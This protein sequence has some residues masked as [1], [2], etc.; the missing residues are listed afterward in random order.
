VGDYTFKT[1]PLEGADAKSGFA[2]G[3]AP[4]DEYLARYAGQNQRAGVSRTWVLRRDLGATDVP[5]VLGY[6]TITLGSIARDDVP[7]EKI[8]KKLPGHPAPVVRIGRLASDTRTRGKGLRVG[9]RLLIDAHARALGVSTQAGCIGVVV[10]AK[11]AN[12]EHFYA[13]YGYVR[14]VPA[15]SGEK[16]PA[17]MYISM[18]TIRTAFG[19]DG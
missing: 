3:S 16:W 1:Q 7:A 10:D 6:Y 9:E 17:P 19:T 13:H 12:A 2:C 4:L 11:D 18:D 5:A 15:Q 14:V 8:R